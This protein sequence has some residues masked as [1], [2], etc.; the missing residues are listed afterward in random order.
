M[1]VKQFLKKVPNV[2]CGLYIYL[3]RPL[4]ENTNNTASPSGFLCLPTYLLNPRPR[5]DVIQWPKV[6]RNIIKST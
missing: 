6:V 1:E 2:S 3:S 5:V 4:K